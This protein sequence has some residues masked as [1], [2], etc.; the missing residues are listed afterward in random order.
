VPPNSVR[1]TRTVQLR[2]LHLRVSPAPLNYNSPD[3]PVCHRTIRCTKRSNGYQRNGRLQR[4]PVNATVRT[5]CAQKTE[6]PSE[7]HRTVNSVCPVR[8]WTVR[9]HKKTKLQRS[10]APEPQRLGDVAGAPDCPV[11][12]S[13]AATPT[14]FWW[15]RAINTPNHLHSNHPSI[16]HSPFNTRAK[17]NTPR[18]NS[19]P[20]IQS[21]SPIQF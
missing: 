9:C 4:T 13:T 12:P 10:S 2:T 5:Q 16:H 7:A 21:K 20:P 11:H 18:H 19:K 14:V 1:C 3:C 8:H 17:C 15:L 6:Q